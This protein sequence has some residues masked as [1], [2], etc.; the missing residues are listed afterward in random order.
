MNTSNGVRHDSYSP[1]A[2]LVPV[3]LLEEQASEIDTL[4]EEILKAKA[5]KE[6]A[7]S[8]LDSR[9][10]QVAAERLAMS[11]RE[12][13]HRSR[14]EALE[15]DLEK[16][17]LELRSKIAFAKMHEKISGELGKR[18]SDAEWQVAKAKERAEV[19]IESHGRSAATS[20]LVPLGRV[21]RATMTEGGEPLWGGGGGSG[22]VPPSSP[23]SRL[24]HYSGRSSP[25]GPSRPPSP[26]PALIPTSSSSRPVSAAVHNRHHRPSSA[27]SPSLSPSPSQHFGQRQHSVHS[28]LASVSRPGTAGAYRQSSSSSSPTSPTP[29]PTPTSHAWEGW[30]SQVQA[31]LSSATLS[32][33]PS[34]STGAAPSAPAL[35]A[36]ET[37]DAIT[38]IYR[39]KARDDST[40]TS[41]NLPP[42]SLP[43]FLALYFMQQ[44]SLG[45]QEALLKLTSLVEGVRMHAGQVYEISTFGK[46]T[47]II[48]EGSSA[49]RSI[50]RQHSAL[51]GSVALSSAPS[52]ASVASYSPGQTSPV[53]PSGNG[54]GS[55]AATLVTPASSTSFSAP[56]A[57]RL[58]GA[59]LSSRPQSGK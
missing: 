38:R 21:D 17:K 37:L 33:I 1:L 16:L 14:I 2:Q 47:G 29:T 41:A 44:T 54:G 15:K 19:L 52:L 27:A 26:G 43:R 18:V 49:G 39:E 24:Q 31:A 57:S 55:G 22:T 6:Q 11:E 40:C 23:S 56:R 59:G 36:Q 12:L 35:S 28:V 13:R 4:K 48:G 32:S 20:Y 51:V 9:D 45:P 34:P 46:M 42:R 25:S 8:D 5:D 30:E 7:K 53:N 58:G 3:G 50:S 10:E